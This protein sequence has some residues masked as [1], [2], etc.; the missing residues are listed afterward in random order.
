MLSKHSLL[1][2]FTSISLCPHVILHIDIVIGAGW[3]L[4]LLLTSDCYSDAQTGTILI[5]IS[6]LIGQ[7]VFWIPRTHRIDRKLNSWLVMKLSQVRSDFGWQTR[8]NQNIQ[9][10]RVP[11]KQ[12]YSFWGVEFPQSVS[13]FNF[14]YGNQFSS[15][16]KVSK[17]SK[18]LSLIR[19]ELRLLRPFLRMHHHYCSTSR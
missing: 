9:D 16:K 7:R 4:W 3:T 10:S 12:S 13:L 2:P 19:F 18:V 15:R 11:F 5:H 14:F 8:M 17:M 6:C 1:W